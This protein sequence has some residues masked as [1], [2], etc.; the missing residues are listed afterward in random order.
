M[1][2]REKFLLIYLLTIFLVVIGGCG[3]SEDKKAIYNDN[4]KIAQPND[5]FSYRTRQDTVDSNDTFKLIYSGFYGM[6]TIWTLDA[7]DNGEVTFT[8]NSTVN[9]GDFKAV[10]VYPNQ[11]VETIFTGN[12]QGDRKIQLTKGKYLFKLVGNN[13]AGETN[14]SISKNQN[15][16]ITKVTGKE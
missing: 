3:V 15:V 13:A 8:C 9:N 2:L 10:L 4:A 1:R 7:K 14:I 6:E 11:E 12:Q 16:E 5:S